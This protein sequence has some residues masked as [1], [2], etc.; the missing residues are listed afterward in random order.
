MASPKIVLVTGANSGIGYE[1]VKA[2]LES[3]KLYHVIMSS[4]S[5][6][7]GRL[8]FEA[9]QRDCTTS[10]NTFEL[11]QLDL[12]SDES[13]TRAFEHVQANHGRVDVLVNNAGISELY[14]T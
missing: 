11:I 10:I 3:D 1:T 7:K 12:T 14:Y 13:I 6:E 8:A 5:L 9:L 4:R 2:L